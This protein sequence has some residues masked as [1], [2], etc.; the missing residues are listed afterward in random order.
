MTA[1][2]PSDHPTRHL[3]EAIRSDA[4]D[5]VMC[6]I[7]VPHCPTFALSDNEADGPRGRIS[8]L[9]GISQ[10][11]LAPDADITR[12]LDTCL[13]CRAC[14]TVCPSGVAYGRLIDNGRARLAQESSHAAHPKPA[15]RHW[16]LLRDQLLTRRRR[17]G[18][19]WQLVRLMQR[20]GLG[21][22]TRRLAG[23]VGR[24]LPRRVAGPLSPQPRPSDTQP[25]RGRVGLFVGCTG[26]AM[27]ANAVAA[28]RTAIAAFGYEVVEP[29]G[30]GCCGAMHAHGGEPAEA[31]R[32]REAN[33][34]V[35]QAAG[36]EAI[37][38]VGTACAAELGPLTDSHE[39]TVREITDWLLA[40]DQTEWPDVA[41]LD[42]RVAVHTPCS[43][44]NHLRQ[45]EATRQ[46]L[47]SIPGLELLEIDGNARCCGAAGMQVLLYPDQAEQLREPKLDS[48]EQLAPDVVV[49]AN[50]GCATHLAAGAKLT[51]RQPVELLAESI[52]AASR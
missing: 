48:I 50:V 35:F 15:A 25:T 38:V 40:R 46:L 41:R 23:P 37:V 28:A 33:A 13:T 6:G 14:E 2:D 19:A 12:H 4:L 1:T 42:Y 43:Q 34:A 21:G 45:P 10:G 18:A 5:C 30:Q 26:A 24:A 31:R 44:R 29:A 16:R 20:L 47:A 11:E 8:L 27:N 17:L 3:D 49:S 52:A 22:L 51:V 9:L 7:C 39:I 32:R 36:V